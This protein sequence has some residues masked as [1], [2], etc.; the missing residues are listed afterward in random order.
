MDVSAAAVPSAAIENRCVWLL[1]GASTHLAKLR[2]VGAK[3]IALEDLTF[4][5]RSGR[6]LLLDVFTSLE[7]QHK[8]IDQPL[9]KISQLRVCTSTGTPNMGGIMI[10]V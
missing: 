8:A 10:L 6:R 2:C 5:A 9:N 7:V 1:P 3:V 4:Y